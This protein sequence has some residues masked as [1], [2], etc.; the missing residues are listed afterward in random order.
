MGNPGLKSPGLILRNYCKF[1]HT[2]FISSFACIFTG[3]SLKSKYQ[4][5]VFCEVWQSR[6]THAFLEPEGFRLPR[7]VIL[8]CTRIR[9]RLHNKTKRTA[10]KQLWEYF[11]CH[12]KTVVSHPILSV[13]G[14]SDQGNGARVKE[15]RVTP[16]RH[17]VFLMSLYFSHATLNFFVITSKWSLFVTNT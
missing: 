1:R 16:L 6:R 11:H 5:C 10:G 7:N 9:E 8:G 12:F 3:P 13:T 15:A 17:F 14:I 4:T 2:G